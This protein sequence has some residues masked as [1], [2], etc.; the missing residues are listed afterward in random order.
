MAPKTWSLSKEEA[1]YKPAPQP[2]VSCGQCMWMFPRLSMGSCK[3]V[4]GIVRAIDTCDEFEPRGSG[5]A[6]G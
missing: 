5:A 4:R 1:H 2:A 6:K 3:Y